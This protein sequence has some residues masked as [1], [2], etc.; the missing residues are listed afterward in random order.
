MV[1]R[2]SWFHRRVKFNSEILLKGS[3]PGFALFETYFLLINFRPKHSNSVIQRDHSAKRTFPSILSNRM[4]WEPEIIVISSQSNHK[5]QPNLV[6][7]AVWSN[8]PWRTEMVGAAMMLK[9]MIIADDPDYLWEFGGW[10]SES[11]DWKT[12]QLCRKLVIIDHMTSSVAGSYRVA[13]RNKI[14]ETSCL[15]RR[16]IMGI[17][18]EKYFSSK[19]L[20]FYSYFKEN[21]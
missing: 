9:V 14:L 13:K 18:H 7:A 1:M 2:L 19:S 20:K 12:G 11:C 5:E 17:G 15:Y 21:W 6:T 4:D 8:K 16:Y 3:G 10:Q